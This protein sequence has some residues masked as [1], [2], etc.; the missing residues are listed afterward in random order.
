M[1]ANLLEDEGFICLDLEPG[2]VSMDTEAYMDCGS[3]ENNTS[4]SGQATCC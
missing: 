4:S 1:S 2:R 3:G